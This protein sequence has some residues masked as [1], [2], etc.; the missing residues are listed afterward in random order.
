MPGTLSIPCGFDAFFKQVDLTIEVTCSITRVGSIAMQSMSTI[1]ETK[2][3]DVTDA[4][5][6]LYMYR[7]SMLLRLRGNLH[8]ISRLKFLFC[9]F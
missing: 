3:Y 5:I 9:K 7:F 2:E 8:Q 6:F 4:W 1:A